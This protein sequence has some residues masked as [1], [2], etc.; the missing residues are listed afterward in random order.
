M[1]ALVNDGRAMAIGMFVSIIISLL[2]CIASVALVSWSALRQVH[3][4]PYSS[5]LR[6]RLLSVE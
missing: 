4:T 6:T 5:Y 2:L 3:T 1:A